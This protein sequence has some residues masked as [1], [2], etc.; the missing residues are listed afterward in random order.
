MPPVR[1]CC[2]LALLFALATPA[3]AQPSVVPVRNFVDIPVTAP[4][5][6]AR[7]KSA[8]VRSALIANWDV[9]EDADGSL[10]VSQTKAGDYAFRFR[11][12]FDSGKYSVTYVDSAGLRFEDGRRIDPSSPTALNAAERNERRYKDDKDTPYAVNSGAGY[13]HPFYEQSVRQ[14]LAGVRRHLNAPI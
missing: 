9:V 1:L 2:C 3:S 5:T 8:I 4:S 10:L 11:V 13:I 6:P 12:R 14:L 7:V